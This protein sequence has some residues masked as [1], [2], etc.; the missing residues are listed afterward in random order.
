MIQIEEIKNGNKL[1]K[2]LRLEFAT[3][4]KYGAYYYVQYNWPE[5][6]FFNIHISPSYDEMTSASGVEEIQGLNKEEYDSRLYYIEAFPDV[7]GIG[8]YIGT[9]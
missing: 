5:K 6:T 2:A 4:E 1:V 3:R 7:N 9:H 8:T